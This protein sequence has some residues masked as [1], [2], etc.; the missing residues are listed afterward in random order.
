V[1]AGP[2]MSE[3]EQVLWQ[4]SP[5]QWTNF[6]AF[7]ACLLVIPIPWAIWRWL[8][9]R[10][11]TY[12]VTSTRVRIRQGV[13]SRR[14]DSLELYRVKDASFV[15]PFV[16]RLVGIGNVEL[17]T[18]DAT[19]PV[20]VIRGVPD[21]DSLREKILGAVDAVRDRKGVREVDFGARPPI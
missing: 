2:I 12:E 5:S 9:T 14:T 1:S 6:W 20:V 15:Q 21:A 10:S 18:S 3:S 8:S 19:T 4:G 13:F 16:M 7:A 17:E 11:F